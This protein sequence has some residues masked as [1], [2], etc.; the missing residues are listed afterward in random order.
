VFI[1]LEEFIQEKMSETKLPSLTVAA[2][3]GEDVIWARAFGF[4]DVGRGLAAT[5]ET[6]YGIGSVT[7]SFTALAIMQLA[8]QGKL[9]L[10]DFVDKHV[11]FP[12]RP[13][14]ER[15][16][17]MH[18]LTHSSGIPALAYAEAVIRGRTGAQDKW[19]PI[20]SY[21]DLATFMRDANDWTL[22]PPGERWFYLNEGYAALGAVIEKCAGQPYV[23]YVYEHILL[24]LGMERSF[25][26]KAAVESDKDVAVPYVITRSGEQMPSTYAYGGLTADGA[27]ISHVHDLARYVSMYLGGGEY[28]GKRVLSQANIEAMQLPRVTLPYEGQSGPRHYALG[29]FNSPN[30]CGHTMIDHGGSVLVATAFMGFVPAE[31]LGV[32]MLAN[33]SGYPLSQLGQYALCLMLGQDPDKLRFAVLER[34]LGALTGTYETYKGTMRAQVKRAGSLL[35]IEIKDKYNDLTVPL[36]AEDLKGE[37]K[38]FYTLSAGVRVPVEFVVGQSGIELIYERYLMR[39]VSK[40]L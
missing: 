12:V 25:F 33:G 40:T 29:L 31:K 23:D 4:K 16:T 36:I 34:E 39:R 15:V 37:S 2:V 6:L 14:G 32:V 21:D 9:R 24:P 22:F 38:H 19:L 7:K 26:G 17:I 8:E 3:K 11:A 30:F 35:M 10:D 20:A 18:L 28:R 5:T 13:R 1:K 27:L